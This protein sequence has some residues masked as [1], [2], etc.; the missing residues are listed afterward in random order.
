MP[1]YSTKKLYDI[2]IIFSSLIIM[3]MD[4]FIALSHSLWLVMPR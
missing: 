4:H 3:Q 2:T 1:K